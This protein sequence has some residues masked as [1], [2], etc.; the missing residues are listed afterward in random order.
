MK[1]EDLT[2]E[3]VE[4]INDAIRW[5]LRCISARSRADMA[6]EIWVSLLR[7][8]P[9]Y[10]P[11]EASLITWAALIARYR[12]IDILRRGGTRRAQKHG[13]RPGPLPLDYRETPAVAD[14]GPGPVARAIEREELA[15]LLRRLAFSR[16]ERLILALLA[17][18]YS[19]KTAAR[20]VG[21]CE[22]HIAQ[23]LI[24]LRAM[25][26]GGDHG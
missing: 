4:T 19:Q 16:R 18:G 23:I 21:V 12:L 24:A 8:L 22:S 3:Q 17:A 15:R 11:Q 6:Q 10:D 9:R 1:P 20:V 2:A 26:A 25:L 7:E 14:P 13:P 5:T